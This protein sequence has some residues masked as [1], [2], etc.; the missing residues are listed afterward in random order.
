MYHN[1]LLSSKPVIATPT[2]TTSYESTNPTTVEVPGTAPHIKF[3]TDNQ[4]KIDDQI[5]LT[6]LDVKNANDLK[7]EI[8]N[9]K[10]RISGVKASKTDL[11]DSILRIN[12]ENIRKRTDLETRITS[13]TDDNL[14][15]TLKINLNK[16]KNEIE[17]GFENRITNARLKLIAL[18]DREL[19]NL[20]DLL[21]LLNNSKANIEHLQDEI[22]AAQQVVTTAVAGTGVSAAQEEDLANAVKALDT[23]L[24]DIGISTSSIKNETT[25]IETEIKEIIAA[26]E[27]IEQ[28]IGASL[29]TENDIMASTVQEGE[30]RLVSISINGN[31][32]SVIGYV[33]H[34]SESKKSYYGSAD[35]SSKKVA[36][37]I[38]NLSGVV[39]KT[40]IPDEFTIDV[41]KQLL[42][43]PV[44]IVD[45]GNVGDVITFTVDF[46]AVLIQKGILIN[47]NRGEY[48]INM[49]YMNILYKKYCINN[50][51]G[52]LW[53][54]GSQQWSGIRTLGF[55][56]KNY[57]ASDV[58]AFL[59]TDYM[60]GQLFRTEKVRRKEYLVIPKE[61]VHTRRLYLFSINAEERDIMFKGQLTVSTRYNGRMSKSYLCMSDDYK[62]MLKQ[63][64]FSKK[65]NILKYILL[66]Q[67]II[68]IDAYLFEVRKGNYHGNKLLITPSKIDAC[69]PKQSIQRK[70]ML[71]PA[72]NPQ[73]YNK[74]T[75]GGKSKKIRS[76]RTNQRR[77]H[78]THQNKRKTRKL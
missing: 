60:G 76:K 50:E 13:A 78:K 39:D 1:Y 77:T 56:H 21:T 43:N 16:L 29:K 5:E 47:V 71:A 63:W 69:N 61:K 20:G 40:K 75:K 68:I 51:N 6:A 18:Y 12:A 25:A 52:S 49:D 48:T 11:N 37:I 74:I 26:N 36:I 64:L 65:E 45:I 67:K 46:A 7:K 73:F 9:I 19:V 42:V 53:S 66:I 24:L 58:K 4:T 54:S 33:V 3:I 70:L 8:D 38:I 44:H 31:I 27:G 32:V 22:K 17:D 10:K 23:K 28:E 55:S 72:H 62:T 34:V 59:L 14:K 30:F 41:P 35:D 2:P 57:R 15:M